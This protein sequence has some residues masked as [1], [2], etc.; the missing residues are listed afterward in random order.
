MRVIPCTVYCPPH[1]VLYERIVVWQA[2]AGIVSK[3]TLHPLDLTW[4][5]HLSVCMSFTAEPKPSYQR[6]SQGRC[7]S[8][9]KDSQYSIKAALL[10]LFACCKPFVALVST[11]VHSERGANECSTSTRAKPWNRCCHAAKLRAYSLY[12]NTGMTV[13]ILL[14]LVRTS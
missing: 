1:N 5:P 9:I 13:R 4:Q 2:E 11:T 12:V 3:S 7:G 14:K 6:F 10:R 8:H